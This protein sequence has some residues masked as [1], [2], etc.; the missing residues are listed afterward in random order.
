[1]AKAERQQEV[2]CEALVDGRVR[3]WAD[4]KIRRRLKKVGALHDIKNF[5]FFS[6][7]YVDPRYKLI[8]VIKEVEA[9]A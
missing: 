4:R 2:K 8:D 3:V 1:M 5:G 7:A 9:L 6:S